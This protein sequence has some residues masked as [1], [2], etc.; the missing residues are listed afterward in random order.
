MYWFAFWHFVLLLASCVA[1][2]VL[3]S[4][5]FAGLIL[6]YFVY[7]FVSQILETSVCYGDYLLNFI[8]FRGF[9]VR[10]FKTKGYLKP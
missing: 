3:V 5:A 2:D 4:D 7:S 1:F 10:I 8:F 9:L 6:F